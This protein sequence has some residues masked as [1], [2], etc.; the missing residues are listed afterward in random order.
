MRKRDIINQ[1]KELIE[2]LRIKLCNGKH[3]WV[4]ANRW[5]ENDGTDISPCYITRVKSVCNKC[6]Q[7]KT[8][9][10]L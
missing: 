7:T 10:L 2:R 8:V 6:E 4:E 3:D 9:I 1:Q 5:K